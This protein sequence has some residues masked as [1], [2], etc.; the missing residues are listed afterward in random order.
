MNE[1]KVRGLN[2][3]RLQNHE[4][5]GF[6]TEFKMELQRS[7]IGPLMP[8]VAQLTPLVAEE[9]RALE[10]IRRSEHTR[11]LAELDTACDNCYRGLIKT[12]HA[13]HHSP[14]TDERDAADLLEIPLQ[15]YGNF[16]VESY[17]IQHSKT[18]NLIQDLRLPKYKPAADL[19]GVSRWVERLEKADDAFMTL[20]RIRRDEQAQTAQE[21]RPLRV[22]RGEVERKYR[23]IVRHINALAVLQP[24]AE[25]SAL[26]ARINVHIDRLNAAMATRS[27]RARK[28]QEDETN[29]G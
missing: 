17:E 21:H 7:N 14:E 18:R 20:Y 10:W 3:A 11:Q 25:L 26:I 23:E 8:F 28:K 4:Q 24:H 6:I 5:F 15:T 19:L 27:T 22:I 16:T 12:V 9:D 1:E 13:A 2:I 29:E